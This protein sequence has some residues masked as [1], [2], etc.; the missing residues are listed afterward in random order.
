MALDVAIP[1]AVATTRILVIEDGLEAYE[2]AAPGDSPF[3]PVLV[4][5]SM[6]GMSSVQVAQ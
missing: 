6:P 3:D 5:L 1:P 2:R 4:D